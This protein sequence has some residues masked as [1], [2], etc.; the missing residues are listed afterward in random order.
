M[1]HI[2][3]RLNTNNL[4]VVSVL[5]ER[6]S[7]PHRMNGRTTVVRVVN[8]RMPHRGHRRLE[9]LAEF[10]SL[11]CSRT[12]RGSRNPMGIGERLLSLYAFRTELDIP[13]VQYTSPMCTQPY[14]PNPAHDWFEIRTWPFPVSR[15]PNLLRLLRK[16]IALM[17]SIYGLVSNCDVSLAGISEKYTFRLVFEAF[18]PMPQKTR[19]R[20]N[21]WAPNSLITSPTPDFWGLVLLTSRWR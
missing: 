10:S 9:H 20:V 5:S 2:H 15:L 4:W 17:T 11:Q 21:Q 13:G 14:A 12:A 3:Q 16:F 1:V 8:N 7:E 19:L 6:F 18:C